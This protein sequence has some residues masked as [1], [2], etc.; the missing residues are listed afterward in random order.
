MTGGKHAK[1]SQVVFLNCKALLQ[2]LTEAGWS[3]H[4]S[5]PL[6]VCVC[7]S[8]YLILQQHS[9]SQTPAG[10]YS[11][12]YKTASKAERVWLNESSPHLLFS[13]VSSRSLLFVFSHIKLQSSLSV[14]VRLGFWFIQLLECVCDVTNRSLEE[15]FRKHL[16]S[17]QIWL[18][19]YFHQS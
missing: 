14:W 18:S 9:H 7:V 2:T 13:P 19:Y 16:C 15:Q 8:T 12:T 11:K 4:S 1:E 17:S 5:S 6:S 3:K 10:F